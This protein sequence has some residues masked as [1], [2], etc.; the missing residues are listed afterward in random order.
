VELETIQKELGKVAQKIRENKDVGGA[1]LMVAIGTGEALMHKPEWW[2]GYIQAKKE[3]LGLLVE[4]SKE[5][6]K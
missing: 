1:Q 3:D 4:P 5:K 2:Q 6:R